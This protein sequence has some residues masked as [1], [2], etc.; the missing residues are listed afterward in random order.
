MAKKIEG[1]NE[2]IRKYS[3]GEITLEECN[4]TL[5][6]MGSPIYLDPN[7]NKITEEELN[8]AVVDVEHPENTT[9]YGRMYHGVGGPEKMFVDHGKFGYD[10]G[11]YLGSFVEFYI[12]GVKFL[13][14][15]DKIVATEQTNIRDEEK[16][17][18]IKP[19][20]D[21]VAVGEVVADTVKVED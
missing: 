2:V 16:E 5:K 7:K 8:A 11:F 10:T 1:I 3:R 6:D 19:S 12:K 15:G 14:D 18:V 21:S 9:G 4:Q 13:V 20:E 17:V